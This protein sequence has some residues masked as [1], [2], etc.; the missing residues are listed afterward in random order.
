M[1]KIPNDPKEIFDEITKDYQG[2]YGKDLTS[3]ILYGSAATGNYIRKKSDINF[4]IVLTEE[5]INQLKKSFKTVVKWHKR[6]VSI[7][8]FLTKSYISSSLDSFPIEFLNMQNGYQSVFGEDVLKELP[9]NKNHLRLQCERELK[10][11]LLQLRQVYL[12][13]RGKTRNLKFIIE[14]SLTAFLSIFR[15]LLY[16]KDKDIPA[17][18]KSIISLISQEMGVD[19]Q[20]F[21]NLLKVKEGT[22]K[23]STEA[24]NTL[25]FFYI[26]EARKLSYTV[27]QLTL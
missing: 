16:L 22:V 21:L 17:E 13:S 25:F 4:L 3:I 9:F 10:G 8:L 27:N 23:L 26:K 7:P 24:L 1:A 15:A 5:G 12:E 6:K 19:E 11:K 18:R 20:V 14:N 2:I